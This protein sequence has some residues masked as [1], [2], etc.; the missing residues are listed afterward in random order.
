M[1]QKLNDAQLQT[2]LSS[3]P[4]WRIHEGKLNRSFTFNS[5]ID[6]FA[7]MSKIALHAEKMNHHP[8]LFNVYNRVDINLSTHDVNGIS[9]KDFALAKTIDTLI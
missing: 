8:E 3:V 7:F 2:A 5:F 1:T 9:D 4:D 6:A